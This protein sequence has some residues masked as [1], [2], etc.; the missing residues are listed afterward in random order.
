MFPLPINLIISHNLY[1][2]IPPINVRCSSSSA[3]AL[4]LPPPA[5]PAFVC[6]CKINIGPMVNI[7]FVCIQ[8]SCSR[9]TQTAGTELREYILKSTLVSFPPPHPLFYLMPPKKKGS[10]SCKVHI[11]GPYLHPE[12]E[13][14]HKSLN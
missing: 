4:P 2:T 13:L 5:H 8:V 6:L 3:T 11:A 14:T 9:R 12:V 1:S 7:T 10:V